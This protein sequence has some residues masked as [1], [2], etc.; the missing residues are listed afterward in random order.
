MVRA[1]VDH[2]AALAEAFQVALPVVARIMIEMR[3]RQ[4]DAGLPELYR[5][6]D[7]RPS[8]R[9]TAAVTP[10]M[11]HSVEPAAIGQ[12]TDGLSMRPAAPLA[13]TT[14]ALEAHASTDLWPVDR[15]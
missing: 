10:R 8:R 2:M 5:L 7:I 1:I 13:D 4:D 15:V 14:G 6:L 3:R 12:A 11:A 9:P